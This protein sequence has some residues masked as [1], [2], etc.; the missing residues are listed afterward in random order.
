MF[1]TRIQPDVK[2]LTVFPK[3]PKFRNGKFWSTANE[4]KSKVIPD[5][6]KMKWHQ[7]GSGKVQLRLPV[8]IIN[9]P[10]ICEAY[11]KSNDKI[12]KRM[13]AR[14]KTHLKLIRQG[15]FVKLGVLK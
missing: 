6:Y 3:D 2:L 4:G 9:Q 7:V 12:D 8:A 1:D 15:K 10:Y 5:G 11:V 13:M 14:F